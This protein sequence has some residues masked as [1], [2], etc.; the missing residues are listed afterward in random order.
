MKKRSIP[1]V[2]ATVLGLFSVIGVAMSEAPMGHIPLNPG[3]Q[4]VVSGTESPAVAVAQ[5]AIGI[6]S[7]YEVDGAVCPSDGLSSPAAT[8]TEGRGCASSAQCGGGICF[9]HKCFC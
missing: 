5:T 8:C 4:V 2:V 9:R 6:A 7:V 3:I 1:L